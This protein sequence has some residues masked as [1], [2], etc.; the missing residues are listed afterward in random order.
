MLQECQQLAGAALGKLCLA[1]S[2]IRL[3]C[4]RTTVTYDLAM[5]TTSKGR[6]AGK[7]SYDERY[8]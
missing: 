8:R 6:L 5:L 4:T 2:P 3:T 7:G 1:V